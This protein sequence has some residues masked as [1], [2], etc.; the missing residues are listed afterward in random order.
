MAVGVVNLF[1]IVEIEVH[2]PNTVAIA[3]G[4]R[5]GYFVLNGI[6]IGQAGND[7][8]IGQHPQTFLGAAFFGDIGTGANQKNFIFAAAAVDE[9]VAEQKQPLAFHRF[10]PAFYLIG[11]TIT[12]KT[13]DVAP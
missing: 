11:G 13:G 9:L 2:Q 5:L 1:K 8:G 10:D 7:V 3:S 6:A 4:D 12:E